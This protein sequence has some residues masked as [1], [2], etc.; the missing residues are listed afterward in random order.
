MKTLFA[1]SW[2]PAVLL[3]VVAC[4]APSSAPPDN[5]GPPDAPSSTAQDGANGATQDSS[6]GGADGSAATAA[7]D[8]CTDAQV[9]DLSTM[10]VDLAATTNGATAD[11][12]APCATTTRADV[13]FKFTLTRRQ[14]VYADTF[15]ASAPTA[16][17]FATSCT[18]PI[19]HATTDGDA[20]CSESACGTN[21]S[22][23]AALLDPGTYYLILAGQGAATIHFQHLEVGSGSVSNLKPGANTVSGTT[24]GAGTLYTC[25]AGGPENAYW[26]RTCPGDTGGAFTGSTCT[27]TSFDTILSLQIPSTETVMCDDD[28]CSFQSSVSGAIPAGAGLFAIAVDGFSSAKHGTYT[29]SI[30]RP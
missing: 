16:L 23:V 11:L 8:R 12:A 18:T 26:W 20:V 24:A 15:G 7:N 5:Q 3:V 25:D 28:T 17:F 30:A 4:G 6:P 27:G 2:S 10:H 9:I 14:L 21:Q 19:T 13:F 1:A 22:Q 29:L